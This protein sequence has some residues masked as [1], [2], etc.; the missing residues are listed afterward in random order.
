MVSASLVP[1]EFRMVRTPG[2]TWHLSF[3]TSRLQSLPSRNPTQSCSYP[4]YFTGFAAYVHSQSYPMPIAVPT[5]KN[6]N[7][8][9][10]NTCKFGPVLLVRG[11]QQHLLCLIQIA[12]LPQGISQLHCLG[13]PRFLKP[14]IRLP[15]LCSFLIPNQP[16]FRLLQ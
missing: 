8:T 12:L 4:F 9:T 1:A 13:T 6:N 7:L 16:P 2:M 10:S 11:A 5:Y 14:L 15:V 3:E